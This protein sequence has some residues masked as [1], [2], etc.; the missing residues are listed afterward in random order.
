MTV[1][2]KLKMQYFCPSIIMLYTMDVVK[3]RS[4]HPCCFGRGKRKNNGRMQEQRKGNKKSE[5][6]LYSLDI[7]KSKH[8]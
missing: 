5:H 8:I 7:Q 2:I 6:N 1:T 4:L 3:I